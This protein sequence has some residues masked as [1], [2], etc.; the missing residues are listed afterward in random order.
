MIW[1]CFRSHSRDWLPGI[2][3]IIAGRLAETYYRPAIAVSVEAEYSRASARSIPEFDIVQALNAC[4]ELF[5]RFGG[6]S[7]AAGFTIP[8]DHMKELVRRLTE[9]ATT[10]IGGLELQ[11]ELT[12]DCTASPAEIEG[13]TFRFM[14]Q[15]SPFGARNPLPLFTATGARVVDRRTV[16]QGRHLRMRLAHDGAQWDAIAFRQGAR[17]ELARDRIDIAYS[18]ELN[19]WRGRKTMQL[20]IEDLRPSAG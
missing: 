14:R 5:T 3:G 20:V 1:G 6:H 16:G 10:Q 13:E 17:A 2:L 7:Q 8:T 15:L 18:M 12:I 19:E 4:A 9:D 11:P